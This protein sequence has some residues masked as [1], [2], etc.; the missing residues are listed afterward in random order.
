MKNIYFL[1]SLK[2]GHCYTVACKEG[3]ST[4]TEPLQWTSYNPLFQWLLR[5]TADEQNGE[6][7]QRDEKVCEGGREA[8]GCPMI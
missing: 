6:Y 4:V 5:A 1:K 2:R 7:D 3:C 8:Q